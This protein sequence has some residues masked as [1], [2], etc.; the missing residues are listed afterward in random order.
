MYPLIAKWTILPGKEAEA[1]E[2]LKKL[3]EQVKK[4]PG[5]LLYLVHTPDFTQPSLP[6]PAAGEVIFFEIYKDK[7]AFLDHLNGAAF[8]NFVKEHGSLFLYNN[9]QPF[10]IVEMLK[11][12]GGFIKEELLK[13]LDGI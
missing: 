11:H 6:T 7:A 10:V 2:I 5:T 9:N 3:P 8:T 12:Q 13:D 4:E 1:I